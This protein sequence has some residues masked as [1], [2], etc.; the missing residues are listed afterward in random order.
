[1]LRKSFANRLILTFTFV[2]FSSFLTVYLLFNSLIDSHIRSEAEAELNREITTFRR[3]ETS[4]FVTIVNGF[5][6][7]NLDEIIF[8]VPPLQ[9]NRA[10]LNVETIILN[11][12]GN[13]I[14]PNP[15]ILADDEV[16]RTE[17]LADFFLN[18]KNLFNYS[19]DMVMTT[20]GGRS[21]YLRATTQDFSDLRNSFF[22]QNMYVLI[23]TDITNAINLKNSMNQILI[24]LLT[25]AATVAFVCS[26]ILSKR[27]KNSIKRLENHAHI[28][29]LGK[30]E[31]K[32][33]DFSYVEFESLA[34]SMNNM[35][36]ML[37]KYEQNQK[38]F[39]QNASHEL[40]TPLM[41][42]QGYAEGLQLGFFENDNIATDVIMEE[43]KKMACLIDDILYLSRL[44]SNENLALSLSTFKIDEVIHSAKERI[45]LLAETNQKQLFVM[46]SVQIEVTAD[47]EKLERAIL[48]I[49][50]NAVRYAQNVIV[51]RSENRAKNIII[52]IS[53]DGPHISN[54][55]LPH[56]FDRFY[57]G[58]NGNT[59]LGMAITKDIIVSL[60][61][62]IKVKNT[63]TGVVF[64]IYLPI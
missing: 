39:F 3:I 30:F 45:R 1:M 19:D 47:Y 38:Q 8:R 50:S 2:V 58:K 56:I 12:D 9:N 63:K 27:F 28:I 60:G 52:S 54:S 13:I 36:E 11:S 42:I 23:Y 49:L 40:R 4:P 7:N 48:N 61:G 44:T 29:G 17:H 51:I 53:N 64:N 26:I 25:T 34:G 35:S 59:G 22:E 6:P 16:L 37:Q 32:I 10:I 5:R 24:I 57:K 62:R 46:P 18:N 43:S 55:D 41:S 15:Q 21:F 31:D 33:S 14:H 20:H